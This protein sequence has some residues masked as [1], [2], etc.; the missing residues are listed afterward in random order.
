MIA[1]CVIWTRISSQQTQV[2]QGIMLL[3]FTW[4]EVLYVEM[5]RT[6]F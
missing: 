2:L 1:I 3:E 4:L 5:G 6:M